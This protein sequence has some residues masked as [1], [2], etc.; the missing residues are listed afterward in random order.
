M[1]KTENFQTNIMLICLLPTNCILPVNIQTDKIWERK[2]TLSL[3]IVNRVCCN[4][5]LSFYFYA[6]VCFFNYFH[7]TKS[8]KTRSSLFVVEDAFGLQ[9]LLSLFI[10]FAWKADNESSKFQFVNEEKCFV[11]QHR[12]KRRSY[13]CMLHKFYARCVDM[14]TFVLSFGLF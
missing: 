14:L 4:N 3:I 2:T 7:C 11:M 5:V 9:K 8:K 10:S 13:N 6:H 12:R 1:D